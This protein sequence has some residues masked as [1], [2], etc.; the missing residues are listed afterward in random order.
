MAILQ[1]INI[2]AAPNDG[3]GDPLRDSFNKVNQNEAALNSDIGTNTNDITD[4]Q[5]DKADK[6]IP[7]AAG[8]IAGLDGTGN[9]IDKGQDANTFQIIAYS[10]T[11]NADLDD[12]SVVEIEITGNITVNL[13]NKT[14][15]RTYRV[16]ILIDSISSPVITL[17]ASFGTI[18]D[19]SSAIWNADNV[20]NEIIIRVSPSG[21][22]Y[23][24]I[25]TITP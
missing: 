24:E 7:S 5:T 18:I 15:G 11:V 8:N 23:Y 16:Y 4:L 12:G 22:T 9:L 3:T 25:N 17:G 6:I 1:T 19:N 13:L 14:N 21:L 20:M 2:G 10:S